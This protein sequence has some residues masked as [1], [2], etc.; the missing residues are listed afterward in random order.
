MFVVKMHC[1]C[2]VLLCIFVEIAFKHAAVVH[3]A[4]GS[5]FAVCVSW[6]ICVSMTLEIA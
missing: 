2:Q 6:S 3:N 4:Q 1:R 5:N